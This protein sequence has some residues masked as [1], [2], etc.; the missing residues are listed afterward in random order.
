MSLVN[1]PAH[2]LEV[3]LKA[4]PFFALAFVS[5]KSKQWDVVWTLCKHA[6]GFNENEKTFLVFFAND[7][8]SAKLLS[9]ILKITKDWKSMYMFSNGIPCAQY[10]VLQWIDCF[11]SSFEVEDLRAHCLRVAESYLAPRPYLLPCKELSVWKIITP[12]H[13]SPPKA[14]VQAEAARRG[15]LAC[16][17]F[18]IDNFRCPEENGPEHF[19]RREILT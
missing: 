18:N 16:P 10:Q 11:A 14:Q 5:P 13:P 2:V 4:K 6:Q 7:A 1:L 17:N 3:A 15:Y 9:A 8:K 19:A 12:N